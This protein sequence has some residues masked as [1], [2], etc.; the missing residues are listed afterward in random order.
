MD[1]DFETFGRMMLNPEVK[2]S[3]IMSE[4]RMVMMNATSAAREENSDGLH[5]STG[6]MVLRDSVSVTL[7]GDARDALSS[8]LEDDEGRLRTRSSC[9]CRSAIVR[10]V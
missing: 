5:D 7:R 8:S 10:I 9:M 2:Y 1:R 4:T 3:D 6:T